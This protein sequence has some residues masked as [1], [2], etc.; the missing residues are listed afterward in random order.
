MTPLISVFVMTLA[1]SVRAA[2]VAPTATSFKFDP[3]VADIERY[4]ALPVNYTDPVERADPYLV[5][6]CFNKRKVLYPIGNDFSNC[7][8]QPYAL[9]PKISKD[10]KKLARWTLEAFEADEYLKAL[11]RLATEAENLEKAKN[12][13]AA[14]ALKS[15]SP[16]YT[17]LKRA[18]TE[19]LS[20]KGKYESLLE[21]RSVLEPKLSAKYTEMLLRLKSGDVDPYT[22][23]KLGR[24]I[25]VSVNSGAL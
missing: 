12:T 11:V 15:D 1:I 4:S 2:T 13:G 23:L 14:A 7:A 6:L 19:H 16:P 5:R 22:S 21:K 25:I 20:A 17:K 3:S 9:N 10:K 24:D 8:F 18:E